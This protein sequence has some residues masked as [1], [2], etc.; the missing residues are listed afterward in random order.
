MLIR[1]KVKI[2][3]II[4]QIKMKLLQQ[5]LIIVNQKKKLKIIKTKETKKL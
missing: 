5:I 1:M 2:Q 3:Q 4:E